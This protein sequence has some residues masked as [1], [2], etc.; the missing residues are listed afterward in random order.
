MDPPTPSVV[1][2]LIVIVT[3]ILLWAIIA[4]A[5]YGLWVLLS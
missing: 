4:L 5:G 2:G 1:V 3:A